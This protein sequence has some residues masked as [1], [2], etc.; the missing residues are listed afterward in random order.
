MTEDQERALAPYVQREKNARAVY[1]EAMQAEP[2]YDEKERQAHFVN[3][4][5]LFAAL[6]FAEQELNVARER[7]LKGRG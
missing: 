7:I 3:A 5:S 4:R 1:E 6:N 2:P